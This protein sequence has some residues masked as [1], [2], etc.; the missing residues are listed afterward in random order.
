MRILKNKFEV[1]SAID[2]YGCIIVSQFDIGTNEMKI[3]TANLET[4]CL[5]VVLTDTKTEPGSRWRNL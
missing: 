5:N 2:K 3:H 1:S 4:I